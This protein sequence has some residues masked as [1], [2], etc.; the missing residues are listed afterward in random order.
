[1]PP[2][3]VMISSIARCKLQS[4]SLQVANRYTLSRRDDAFLVFFTLDELLSFLSSSS[5]KSELIVSMFINSSRHSCRNVSRQST[6]LTP[7]SSDVVE[8]L[9]SASTYSSIEQFAEI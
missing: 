6:L 4:L 8:V 5:S 9:L 7:T 1:M 2:T 3:V